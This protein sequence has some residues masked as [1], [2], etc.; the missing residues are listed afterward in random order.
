MG[1]T[2]PDHKIRH[3]NSY[4]EKG[5]TATFHDRALGD[6]S[7]LSTTWVL[8]SYHIVVYS[9]LNAEVY[10]FHYFHYFFHNT[11]V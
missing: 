2:V 7:D 4:Q 8:C 10:S 6:M 1:R 5:G 9:V 3:M 11:Y